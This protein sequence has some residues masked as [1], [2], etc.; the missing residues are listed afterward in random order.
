MKFKDFQARP[1][2]KY[3]QGLEFRGKIQALSRTFKDAWEP[4]GK[5]RAQQTKK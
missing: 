5:D 4:C 3:F 1:V 2:F